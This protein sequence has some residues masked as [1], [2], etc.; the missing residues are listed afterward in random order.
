M[1]LDF[2][3]WIKKYLP[4]D[5]VINAPGHY[6][7]LKIYINLFVIFISVVFLLIILFVSKLWLMNFLKQE[8]DNMIKWQM[9]NT[10]NNL[11]YFIN[12]KLSSLKFM[13]SVYGIEALK[14]KNTLSKCLINLQKEF[15]E[16]VDIGIIDSNGIMVTYDGPYKMEG[17]KYL[18]HEWFK[19]VAV[20]GVF[21]SDVFMGFRKLPHFAIAIKTEKPGPKEIGNEF[22]VIRITIDAS[23]LSK[24]LKNMTV[25]E[26]DDVF[27]VNG[28]GVVQTPSKMFT[29]LMDSYL[30]DVSAVIDN[31]IKL[32][33]KNIH[34]GKE[35]IVGLLKIKN[36]LWTLITITEPKGDIFIAKL[37]LRELL[38]IFIISVLIILTITIVITQI[39]VNW[40]RIAHEER[41]R[42]MVEIEHSSKL[43]AIGK[44]AAGVAHEINNPLSIISQSAGLITDFVEINREVVDDDFKPVLGKFEQL[45]NSI[46]NAV[47]RCHTITH[48]LLGFVRRVDVKYELINLK[49]AIKEVIGF[50]EKELLYKNIQLVENYDAALPSIVTDKGLLQQVILNIINNAFDAVEKGGII[51]ISVKPIDEEKALIS[52]RDNGHGIKPEQVKNIFEPFYTTKAKGKGTGLGL[53]ISHSIVKKMGGTITVDSD[54]GRGACFMIELPLKK[55]ITVNAEQ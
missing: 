49:D 29:G 38:A 35:K 28:V 5:S 25:N 6:R 53:S 16:I 12:T 46:V 33:S 24:L 11:E 47:G 18:D 55:E 15:G 19:Q 44:L 36:T 2:K 48:R 37:F 43:A 4:I 27:L 17:N 1:S 7:R 31:N 13:L 41:E 50:L 26:G 42:A 45:S 51:E 9:E 8:T 32:L 22:L 21:I 39:L 20:Q 10:K 54:I 34:S 40:I 14:D 3:Y 23:T 52:I 30:S